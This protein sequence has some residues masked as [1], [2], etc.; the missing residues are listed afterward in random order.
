[1]HWMGV[2]W[3]PSRCRFRRPTR[4]VNERRLRQRMGSSS[5]YH[6]L[7]CSRLPTNREHDL[8]GPQGHWQIPVWQASQP[9]DGGAVQRHDRG[10]AMLQ[11]TAKSAEP[12]D[13]KGWLTIED[14]VTRCRLDRSRRPPVPAKHTGDNERKAFRIRASNPTNLFQGLAAIPLHGATH[15]RLQAIQFL[16]GAPANVVMFLGG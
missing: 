14:S 3:L 11:G 1:M 6:Q 4:T 8:A 10:P 5:P 7:S 2:L 9:V 12:A 13:W 15:G 16:R